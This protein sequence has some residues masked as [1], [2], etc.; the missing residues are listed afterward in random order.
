MD[1]LTFQAFHG[2]VRDDLVQLVEVVHQ[3]PLLLDGLFCRLHFHPTA[4][5]RQ[6]VNDLLLLSRL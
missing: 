6:K 3:R 4:Q 1:R 5:L 2:T